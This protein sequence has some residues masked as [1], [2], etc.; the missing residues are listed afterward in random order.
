MVTDKE[1]P[2]ARQQTG[3]ASTKLTVCSK[4]GGFPISPLGD[5]D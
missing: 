2:K 3:G 4:D 5:A 1:Y